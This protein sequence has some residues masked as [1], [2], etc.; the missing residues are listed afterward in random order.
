MPYISI[1]YAPSRGMPPRLPEPIEQYLIATKISLLL[2]FA[3]LSLCRDVIGLYF[4]SHW[5]LAHNCFIETIDL[6]ETRL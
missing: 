2:H 4:L 3:L 5:K 1:R 6:R